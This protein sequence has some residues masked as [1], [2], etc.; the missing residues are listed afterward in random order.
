MWLVQPTTNLSLNRGGSQAVIP[1][2]S[3]GNSSFVSTTLGNYENLNLTGSGNFDQSFL[4]DDWVAGAYVVDDYVRHGSSIYKCVVATSDEPTFTLVTPWLWIAFSNKYNGLNGI[5]GSRTNG[6]TSTSGEFQDWSVVLRTTS[7]TSEYSKLDGVSKITSRASKMT[8]LALMNLFGCDTVSV[9][10]KKS[11]NTTVVFSE[12]YDTGAYSLSTE[13]GWTNYFDSPRNDTAYDDIG[14]SLIVDIP[15]VPLGYLTIT[16]M[17]SGTVKMRGVGGLFSGIA[18]KLGIANYG[19]GLEVNSFNKI[20]PNDFGDYSFVNRGYK[21]NVDYDVILEE[22]TINAVK[23]RVYK[24]AAYPCVYIGDRDK[25]ETI[26]YGV[27]AGFS[28]ILSVNKIISK[29]EIMGV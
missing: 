10:L 21:N 22:D 6:Y 7:E 18:Y 14:N 1:D 8:T 11:D 3:A 4:V 24:N 20:E 26:S 15:V 28:P 16:F 17:A 13:S 25:P 27:V 19:T 12:T 9:E 29:L 23:Q 5:L 2:F